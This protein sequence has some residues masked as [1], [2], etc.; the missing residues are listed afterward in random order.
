MVQPVRAEGPGKE[1]SNPEEVTAVPLKDITIKKGLT[2]TPLEASGASY[3]PDL[4]MFAVV[5]DET[6]KK[7]P[8]LFFM[9]TVGHIEQKTVVG[10]VAEI[11][12]LEGIT[13]D[14]NGYFYL[15]TSQSYNRKRKCS[16]QRKLLLK[17]RR[18]GGQ[19][20]AISSV[21]LTDILLAVSRK[22]EKEAWS[23]FLR[24]A[25]NE[26]SIDVEGICWS[27]DTM[28]IGFKNPKI[29]NKAVVLAICDTDRM[30]SNGVLKPRQIAIWDTLNVLHKA[31]GTFCGISDLFYHREQLFGVS[32]GV[33][34]RHGLSED[35]GVFWRY[36]RKNHV[37]TPI[38]Y[39]EGTKPEGLAYNSDIDEFCIT[40]D[41]GSKNPSQMLIV[42]VSQ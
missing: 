17:V 30:F 36:S 21:S 9:D 11:N 25:V 19:F 35:V 38:Q 14:K 16:D 15:L 12:D 10:M 2:G 5:S 27:H 34:K 3:L 37:M 31:S 42:K 7:R 13:Q 40:F 8:D 18:E 4:K 1:T 33:R 23:V 26:K 39:F 28:L 32:T 41:N 22:A 20:A 6:D 24:R 29:G